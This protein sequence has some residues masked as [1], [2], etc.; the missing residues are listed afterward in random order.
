MKAYDQF[1]IRCVIYA[2]QDAVKIQSVAG[3]FL[4]V[5]AK[6]QNIGATAATNVTWGISVAGGALGLINRSKSGIIKEIPLVGSTTVRLMPLIGFGSIEIIVIVHLPNTNLMQIV[7]HGRILGF[8][9]F[10]TP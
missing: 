8:M 1:S 3:G 4:G 7:K 9:T 2:F 10:I 6:I 5:H